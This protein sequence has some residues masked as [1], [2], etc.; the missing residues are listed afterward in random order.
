MIV[1]GRSRHLALAF[2]AAGMLIGAGDARAAR[3]GREGGSFGI[4]Q[5]LVETPAVSTREQPVRDR[6]RGLLPA[7]AH[8]EVDAKGNLLVT[9]GPAQADETLL[10][11]A[12]MDETGYL[13]TGIRE[14]GGLEVKTVGGFFETLYEGQVVLVH[15]AKGDIGGVVPPRATYAEASAAE[16]PAAFGKEQVWVD[17]GASSRAVTESLGV[18]LGDSVTVPKSFR[19]LH[20]SFGTGRAVDD[21]AGCTA[22]LLAL[23]GIDPKSLRHKVLF[24]FSVEEETGLEGAKVMARTLRPDLAIAVDTFVSSDTPLER[25]AFAHAVLGKGPVIRAVDTTN[26]TDPALLDRVLS[27]ARQA[28]LPIQYGMTRGGNDGSVFP[29]LGV[30][31]LALSWATVHSHSAVEVIHEKD[32]DA[33]GTLVRVIAERW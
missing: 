11:I 23:R 13:V 24:A 32:L 31:N 6:I 2:L 5:T 1:R 30:P 7:W 15:T 9:A 4:L 27:L 18:A 29:E 3:S 12:H 33:L 16:S 22:L 25:K 19:R 28:G 14:N 20:G 10:F 8:P 17:V 26:V 21:R